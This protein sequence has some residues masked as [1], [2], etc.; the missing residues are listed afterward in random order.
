MSTTRPNG[1]QR[2]WLRRCAPVCSALAAL[3]RRE[4]APVAEA[5]RTRSQRLLTQLPTAEHTED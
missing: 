4:L 5:V 1:H 2:S 3:Y